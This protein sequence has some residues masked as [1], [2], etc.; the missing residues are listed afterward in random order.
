[1]KIDRLSTG[2]IQQSLPTKFYLI[3]LNTKVIVQTNDPEIINGESLCYKQLFNKQ[4]PCDNLN[5]NCVCE[6]IKT[7]G[8]NPE[9]LIEKGKGKN[10]ESIKPKPNYWKII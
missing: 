4:E 2:K 10:K 1:M 6:Q 5:G 3:D 9:F 7:E 8:E